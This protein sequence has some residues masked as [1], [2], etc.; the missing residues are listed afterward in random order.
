M[1]FIIGLIVAVGAV[2]GGYLMEGG[3]IPVL[4]H[5]LPAEGTIIFGAALKRRLSVKGIQ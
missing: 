5:P 1:F 2:M 4:L 3:S